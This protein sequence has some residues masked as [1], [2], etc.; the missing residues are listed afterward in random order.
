[1]RVADVAAPAD[2]D[3]EADTEGEAAPADGDQEAD[4]EGEAAPADRMKKRWKMED[5]ALEAETT[6]NKFYFPS[7]QLG[8]GHYELKM[9]VVAVAWAD[10]EDCQPAFRPKRKQRQVEGDNSK[11]GK[12][13]SQGGAEASAGARLGTHLFEV[14]KLKA[15]E[16]ECGYNDVFDWD[17]NGNMMKWNMGSGVITDEGRE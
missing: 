9:Y 4:I 1:V 15:Q 3:Q 13:S 12:P 16:S 7:H 17:F 8:K 14:R 6:T 10:I 11:G 2:G 5:F